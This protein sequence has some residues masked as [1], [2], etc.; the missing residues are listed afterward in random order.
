MAD[1]TARRVLLAVPFAAAL[2]A[3]PDA[4]PQAPQER[5]SF[6]ATATA[7]LVDVVV[8]DRNGR[9]LTDLDAADFE[10]AEDGAGQKIDSFTRVSRGGGIGVSVG[11]RS[12]GTTVVAPPSPAATPDGPARSSDEA[13][14]GIVFDQLSS[15]ALGL[16]QKATLAYVP[17]SGDAGVRVAVFATDP[18]IRTLQP[19]TTDRSLIR[20]AVAGV[21]PA[22]ASAGEQKAER[23]DELLARRRELRGEGD[24][25]AGGATA[26]TATLSQNAAAIGL[27]E[28]ELRM[29][30]TEINMIRASEHL[31]RENRGY[32][33]A[34]A[35]LTVVRALSAYPGRKTIVF[36]SE[37]L[38]ASPVL[39]AKLDTVIDIANRG[40]VTVYAVDANG[41]RTRSSTANMRKEMDAFVDERFRQLATG[42]DRTEQPLTM[43]FERVEDTMRLDSRAGLARLANDTGGFLIDQSNDLTS[44]FRRID[45]DTQFHYLLTYSPRNVEF[46]GKFR[47][48]QVK[49]KRPGAQVFARKGYRALRA[50]PA[51]AT[52]VYEAPALALLDRT[53][54]PNAFPVQF[55]SF[56]FPDPVRP[57]LTPVLVQVRTRELRFDVDARRATYSADAAIVVRVR[58][59]GGNEVEKVTQQYLLTGASGE[60]DAARAGEI[61][62]YRELDLPA[63]V[64]TMESIVFDGLA[65]RGSA[66]LGTLTVGAADA[67][68]LAMSSLVLIRRIEELGAAPRNLPTG[69]APLY[70]GRTLLY[71][72]LGEPIARTSA[73]ELPF[74][75]VLYGDARDVT[76]SAQLLHN[77]IALADAPVQ[78]PASTGPRVQHVGR[79]P[80]GALPVGTYELRI[81]AK[82]GQ[83]EASRSVFF[84]LTQ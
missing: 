81:Q 57:G 70:V 67:S 22:G 2:I 37:G 34:L 4:A 17:M 79:L 52:S 30:Q 74:Y 58:D 3:Q 53:P 73:S 19:F 75:F 69:G 54:L 78:V 46:D 51:D 1:M 21:L 10:L 7:V 71:P 47:T 23:A 41:L 66:R 5:Q 14:T 44:A 11:W 63:G 45:E 56:S 6:T 65:G 43:E 72:N 12:P 38:P 83:R 27:R 26:S 33:T 61:L 20:R 15:E 36:F 84:T 8:R 29:V 25:I 64:Y 42:A 82:A 35:L 55:G 59:S 9:P 80:I 60:V 76:V 31:D 32:D 39:S 48:I 18:S 50:R 68:A 77:G 40:N 13:A 49:V 16:A 24:P 28:T 62:F